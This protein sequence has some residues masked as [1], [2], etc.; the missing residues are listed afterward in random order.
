MD[1][2]SALNS[3]NTSNFKIT[4]PT[5]LQGLFSGTNISDVGKTP[6]PA[7]PLAS[8]T[9][10]QAPSG[11]PTAAPQS[12]VAAPAPQRTITTSVV[13]PQ[14]AITKTQDNVSQLA[15]ATQPKVQAASP[16]GTKVDQTGVPENLRT[17]TRD[18][19]TS[20]FGTNFTG[21]VQ[22]PD[23]TFSPDTTA[24]SRVSGIATAP[25]SVT[26]VQPQ[27]SEEVKLAKQGVADT[28]KQLDSLIVSSDAASARLIESI[29]KEYDSLISQQEQQNRA[30]ESGITTEGIVSGRARYAPIIQAGYVAAA[31]NSGLKALS[32]LQAKK[33]RLIIEA[34]MARDD[35]KLKL[36][37]QKMTEYREAIKEERDIAQKTYENT[38]RA[39]QEARAK[40]Q[41][42]RTARKDTLESTTAGIASTVN[43]ITD[44]A[45]KAAYIQSVANQL[46]VTEAELFSSITNYNDTKFKE[47]DAT[48]FD[49]AQNYPGI[50]TTADIQ[51]HDIASVL[52]KIDQSE[53]Y[54]LASKEKKADT[55]YKLAQAAK[56][57]AEATGGG[58][59]GE[60]ESLADK[61]ARGE[62]PTGYKPL[63]VEAATR[64]AKEKAQEF[65]TGT[66]VDKQTGFMPA[67]GRIPAA[68]GTMMQNQISTLGQI[69]TL[70]GIM[71]KI[72]SYPGKKYL[73]SAGQITAQT[74]EEVVQFVTLRNMV[75]TEFIRAVSGMATT[76]KERAELL[77]NLPSDNNFGKYN[78]TKLDV[79]ESSVRNNLG[80]LT[81]FYNTT[82]K[83]Y[84]LRSDSDIVREEAD[85]VPTGQYLVRD[86]YGNPGFISPEMY[87]QNKDQFKLIKK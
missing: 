64:L 27:D 68:T 87:A 30:Y 83:G 29:A 25:S 42:E 36:L 1:P 56:M 85:A 21:V 6:V 7:S 67:T 33:Q 78:K 60:L 26:T 58:I 44:P 52:S 71:D 86:R 16:V 15:A 22:N 5:N 48:I 46:G 50:V 55:A 57:Q 41:E 47:I 24:Y 76:D 84:D 2:L 19:A 51:N 63:Q 73:N 61:I 8:L 74:P 4:V 10:S 34:E 75:A 65:D 66:L 49:I 59:G 12:Q 32:D 37:N 17:L 3:G 38:I 43:S 54:Q 14:A 11:F 31:V 45:Q 62:K 72:D 82:V 77:S 80:S 53:A 23:G 9:T 70:R 69:Q 35:K 28:R 40:A 79:F 39:S 81:G 18:Q 13:T 20:L